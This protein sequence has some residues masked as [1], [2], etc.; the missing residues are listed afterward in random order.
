MKDGKS[1]GSLAHEI[2]KE[3]GFIDL[4]LMIT[5]LLD[6]AA[7]KVSLSNLELKHRKAKLLHHYV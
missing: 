5:I 6:L 4:L 1:D 3:V 7:L 2:E